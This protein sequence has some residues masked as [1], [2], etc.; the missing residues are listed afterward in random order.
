MTTGVKCSVEGLT[1]GG[2]PRDRQHGE[3]LGDD[4]AKV[5]LGTSGPAL[6]CEG[7]SGV[8]ALELDPTTAVAIDKGTET[9]TMSNNEGKRAH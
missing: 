1:G 8:G 3:G 2:E 9:D 7:V 6:A 4:V 5:A